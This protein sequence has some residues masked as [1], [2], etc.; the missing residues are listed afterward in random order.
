VKPNDRDASER[1]RLELAGAWCA[2]VAEGAMT[3]QM[4]AEFTTWLEADADNVRAFEDAGRIWNAVGLTN[5]SPEL[6]QLR[7]AALESFRRANRMRW[8]RG[9]SQ[10]VGILGG[11]AACLI[12]IIVAGGIWLSRLPEIYR[13]GVGERRVFRLPDGSSLSLDA[14]TRVAVRYARDRRELHLEHGRARFNVTKDPLRPFSVIAADKIVVATGTQFSV[15]LLRKQVHVILY[16]GHVAVLSERPGTA[17]PQP[18]R[19]ELKQ[20]PV[21]QVF[22][23]GREIVMAVAVP[24]AHLTLTDAPR[25]LSWES[26]QL[27][28]EDEPLA[29]AVERVNR[30]SQDRL[31]IGDA[32]AGQTLV[33]G[34]FAAGDTAAFVEGVTGVLRI[35]L[36]DVNGRKQLV[37]R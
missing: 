36:R 4:H 15:E 33:S 21:D 22:T 35:E 20:I 31:E 32:K 27:V 26:G 34:V 25:S 30:Y 28:F 12:V 24:E 14:Q 29:S 6:I 37:S 16:E 7:M 19:L 3:P 18:V 1:T 9:L 13:T 11:I 5:T 10:H 17:A 2:R 8:T 23:P